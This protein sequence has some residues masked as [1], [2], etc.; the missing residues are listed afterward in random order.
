MSNKIERLVCISGAYAAMGGMFVSCVDGSWSR[1]FM[2][3]L[4]AFILSFV[5]PNK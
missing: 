4:F 1:F 3:L 2:F 5:A